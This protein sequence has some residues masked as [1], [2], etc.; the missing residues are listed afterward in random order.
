ME[1]NELRLQLDDKDRMLTA[2]RSAARHR[3]L[4]QLTLDNQSL[5]KET[6]SPDREPPPTSQAPDPGAKRK[7]MDEVSRILDEMIQDRV[8]SGHLIKGARGS[9]RVAPGSRRASESHQAAGPTGTTP[10]NS[11]PSA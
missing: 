7:S 9:V 4:A 3:D 2:L 8:E 1:I 10:L 11:R 6:S 5:P